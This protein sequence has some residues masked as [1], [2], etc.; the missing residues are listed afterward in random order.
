MLVTTSTGWSQ[1]T[2]KEIFKFFQTRKFHKY[3]GYLRPMCKLQTFYPYFTI[4]SYQLYNNFIYNSAWPSIYSTQIPSNTSHFFLNWISHL[5]FMT[6]FWYRYPYCLFT[7]EDT[8]SQN[9]EVTCLRSYSY[10]VLELY[11]AFN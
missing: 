3:V 6:T 10:E 5:I 4:C 8:K 9:N 7:V 2:R 1:G 11:R